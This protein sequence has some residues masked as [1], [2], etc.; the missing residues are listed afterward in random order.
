LWTTV[1][2]HVTAGGE[3]WYDHEPSSLNFGGGTGYAFLNED[4]LEGRF[5]W[6]C[7]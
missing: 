5:Y 4:G 1:R 2:E 7:V 6:E 3:G